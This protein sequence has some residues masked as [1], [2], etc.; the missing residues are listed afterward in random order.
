MSK[1][2]KNNSFLGVDH[3][4]GLIKERGVQDEWMK[5]LLELELKAKEREERFM[6]QKE[7]LYQKQSELYKKMEAQN[8]T[9][10]DHNETSFQNEGKSKRKK[11]KKQGLSDISGISTHSNF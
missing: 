4:Q 1:Y 11:W 3:V 9:F 7:Q 10:D 2:N 5:K 6:K 8:T